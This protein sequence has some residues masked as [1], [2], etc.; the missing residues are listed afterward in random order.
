[1]LLLIGNFLS[2]NGL[3]PTA[4]E[5][6]AKILSDKY[7][8]KTSSDQITYE[9]DWQKYDLLMID[10][11]RFMH[12]RRPIVKDDPRDIVIIQSQRASFGF[13]S[14]TRKPINQTP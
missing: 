14:T 10:N 2:K 7:E 6:L 1:M 12:G 8:I 11:K 4:I 9:H 5:D 3:N 13:G